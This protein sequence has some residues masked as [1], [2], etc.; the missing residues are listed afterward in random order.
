MK[1]GLRTLLGDRYLLALAG[2]SGISNLFEQWIRVLLTIYA[3]RELAIGAAGLGLSLTVGAVGALLGASLVQ[4]MEPR[5][6]TGR[7][8]VLL[9][10]LDC[11]ALAMLP[12]IAQEA[13]GG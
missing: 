13:L 4:W 1:L 3:V 9:T 11:P 2:Y 12:V 6:R 5:F 7:A 8:L 10:A